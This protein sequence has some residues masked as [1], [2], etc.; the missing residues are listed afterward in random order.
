MLLSRHTRRRELTFY[1][2][3]LGLGWLVPSGASAQAKRYRV[4]FLTL[5][6]GDD[7]SAFLGRLLELG[8]VE[9][10]GL[11]YIH[12]SAEGDPKRLRGLAEELVRQKPD[13]I[14]A[15]WGALAPQAAKAA[16]ATIPIIFTG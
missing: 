7:L 2:G 15:G 14:V 11:T 1:L 4:G 12:H 10:G 3:A 6:P 8:Y 9:G 5:E 13:V 16:T